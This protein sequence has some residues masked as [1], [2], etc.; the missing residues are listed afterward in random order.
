[1][2]QVENTLAAIET[3][4]G[5]VR[6]T[7]GMSYS[8][9]LCKGRVYQTSER[10][11]Y[12]QTLLDDDETIIDILTTLRQATDTNNNARADPLT[13]MRWQ[14]R[15][16]LARFKTTDIRCDPEFDDAGSYLTTDRDFD[17][18]INA[19][20]RWMKAEFATSTTELDTFYPGMNQEKVYAM[21]GPEPDIISINTLLNAAVLQAR[22][23]EV[24]LVDPLGEN[25]DRDHRFQCALCL[26]H[27]NADDPALQLT[28]G[29]VVGQTCMSVWLT[30]T[31]AQATS[32]PHCKRLLC[33]PR[34][35]TLAMPTPAQVNASRLRRGKVG[36]IAAVAI[37]MLLK[38]HGL[39]KAEGV[40]QDIVD[41]VNADLSSNGA[42]FACT[43]TSTA[44][45]TS[46]SWGSGIARSRT[47]QFCRSWI[48]WTNVCEA[49]CIAHTVQG[50]AF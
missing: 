5:Y 21:S 22:Q 3:H 7:E 15:Y 9:M 14:A 4:V 43:V 2:G 1:M 6:T 31:N 47:S 24:L 26:D 37:K 40:A 50:R 49:K 29:H 28:C 25:L 36:G 18:R 13:L 8:D 38:T 27:Y 44:A 34:K 19:L 30:S 45:Q 11:E 32:Y 35:H 23:S 41:V 20:V 10:P 17:D 48:E 12:L 33:P 42:Q 16:L 46:W 39:A